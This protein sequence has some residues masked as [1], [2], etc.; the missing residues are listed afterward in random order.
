MNHIKQFF[1]E[2]GLYL[3]CL[4]MVFAATAA[5]ILAL[6][7]IVN[8]VADLTRIRKEALQNDTTWT[9]P[10]A[11]IDK[12]AQDVPK[13][14][15]TPAA[16][17]KPAATAAPTPAAAQAAP[18]QQVTKPG[19][20]DAKPLTGYSGDELIY[21][22]T[23]G[24]WRTHNGADYAAPA[25][26]SVYP[27]KAGRIVAVS[28]DALWGNVV[29]IMDADDVIWRYCGLRAATVKIGDDV[30]TADTLG[31]S[32]SIPAEASGESHLHLECSRNGAYLDPE[33]L[34]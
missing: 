5:G 19:I 7:T 24:D 30:T 33:S 12:P 10:D 34:L 15:Q 9:Q 21:S 18:P 31:T 22:A 13:P 20:W 16:T 14:T 27:A 1:K 8:N 25:G 11:A 6:R 3:F 4:A 26:E 23:L 2:K 17:E 29:E 28:E 32:G